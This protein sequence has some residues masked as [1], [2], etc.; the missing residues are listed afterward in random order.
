MSS[1]AFVLTSIS[2]KLAQFISDNADHNVCTVGRS[3][4]FRG[5]GITVCST[6]VTESPGLKI[7]GL[8]E[9]VKSKEVAKKASL[10]LRK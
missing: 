2:T 4:T 10:H 3:G 5:M 1:D 7:W 6:N 9:F 8:T